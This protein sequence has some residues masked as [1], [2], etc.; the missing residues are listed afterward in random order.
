[1]LVKSS[2]STN[3]AFQ[4]EFDSRAVNK[5]IITFYFLHKIQNITF[6]TFTFIKVYGT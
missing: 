2:V 4:T 6:L 1:M 5:G 3:D